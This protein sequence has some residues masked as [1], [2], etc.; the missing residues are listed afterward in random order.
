MAPSAFALVVLDHTTSFFKNPCDIDLN[1]VISSGLGLGWRQAFG[2]HQISARSFRYIWASEGRSA[3]T[4]NQAV[5]AGLE[6]VKTLISE[7]WRPDSIL[8]CYAEPGH[9]DTKIW[10]AG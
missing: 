1:P 3:F 6:D 2:F 10:A 7:D 5:D 4:E 9:R 8:L